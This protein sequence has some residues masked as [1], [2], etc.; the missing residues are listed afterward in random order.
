MG[1]ANGYCVRGPD[2]KA[3][4]QHLA[5]GL[6]ARTKR[7]SI[8]VA[9]EIESSVIETIAKA[10]W[11]S[12]MQGISSAGASQSN[13]ALGDALRRRPPDRPHE[14]IKT[15]SKQASHFPYHSHREWK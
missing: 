1:K 12:S 15:Y 11:L 10:L 14:K 3:A 13:L 8:D 2:C 7:S 5:F 4:T 9:D 6:Q